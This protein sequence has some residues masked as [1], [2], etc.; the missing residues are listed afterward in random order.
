M[1]ISHQYGINGADILTYNEIAER[2][3]GGKIAV[4]AHWIARKAMAK[5][6][7]KAAERGYV[8]EPRD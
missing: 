7:K 5:L 8:Y 4:H 6:R 3:G 1:V 2:L